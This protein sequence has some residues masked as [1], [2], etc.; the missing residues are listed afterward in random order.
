MTNDRSVIEILAAFLLRRDLQRHTPFQAITLTGEIIAVEARRSADLTRQPA[1]A[2]LKPA[3]FEDLGQALE[4]YE[5]LRLR[6][7]AV[8]N[9]FAE[10]RGRNF[11]IRSLSEIKHEL[12]DL[13]IPL[14]CRIVENI[15][16]WKEFHGFQS[17]S[18]YD[19]LI[20]QI[21]KVVKYSKLVEIT[22]D[23]SYEN[24][25]VPG[26]RLFER[27]KNGEIWRLVPPEAPFIGA[28]EIITH[29]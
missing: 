20:D 29:K 17:Q 15:I 14:G 1:N 3:T 19:E 28:W 23:A 13:H 16:V 2:S 4:T 26:C 21:D 8:L 18:Q 27:L 7:E 10:T 25:M 12:T 5:A 6:T 22:S 11:L 24:W 9:E